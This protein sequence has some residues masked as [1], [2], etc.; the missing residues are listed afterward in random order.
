MSSE[1]CL[2]NSSA[3]D[4]TTQGIVLETFG[5]QVGGRSLIITYDHN[6]VCKPLNPE[7]LRF[8]LDLPE[9]LRP[10]TPRYKGKMPLRVCPP[11]LTNVSERSI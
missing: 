7:E 3:V 8:Y 5:H 10:F 2:V 9:S 1:D 11:A 6:T 4:S